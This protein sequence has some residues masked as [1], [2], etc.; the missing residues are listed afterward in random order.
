M[1]TPEVGDALPGARY[2][3]RRALR[4]GPGARGAEHLVGLLEAAGGLDEGNAA[5]THLERAGTAA[6][7]PGLGSAPAV[8]AA[9]LRLHEAAEQDL[10]STLHR[11]GLRSTEPPSPGRQQRAEYAERT[12]AERDAAVRAVLARLLEDAS[13]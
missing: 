6:P 9:A 4:A 5:R 10:R 7:V 13:G 12:L 1:S 8:L 11:S 2:A 3:L